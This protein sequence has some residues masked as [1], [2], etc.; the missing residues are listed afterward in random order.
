MHVFSLQ[1]VVMAIDIS[2]FPAVADEAVDRD[3]V[4]KKLLDS[5]FKEEV[6]NYIGNLRGKRYV[7]DIYDPKS[8]E[9]IVSFKLD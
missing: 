3:H 6:T 9:I 4:D 1:S 2:L 8:E 7:W 5:A